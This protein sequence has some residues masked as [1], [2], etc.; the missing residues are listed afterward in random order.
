MCLLEP[1]MSPSPRSL[2]FSSTEEGHGAGGRGHMQQ[3][4]AG[5]DC[6]K[7]ARA[8]QEDHSEVWGKR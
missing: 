6:G 7:G 1:H 4:E 5:E 3:S 2:P 8:S